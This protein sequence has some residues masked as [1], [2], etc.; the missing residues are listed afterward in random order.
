M[1]HNRDYER[2]VNLVVEVINWHDPIGLIGGGC[3]RDEYGLELPE[4]LR[5]LQ[6]MDSPKTLEYHLRKIF[7]HW[8][9]ASLSERFNGWPALCEDLWSTAKPMYTTPPRRRKT[10]GQG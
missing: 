2:Y 9:G 7:A 8:F 3:N 5:A 6:D 4:V 1:E 10:D